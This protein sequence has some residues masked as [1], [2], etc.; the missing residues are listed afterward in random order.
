M[1]GVIL[2]FPPQLPQD[3]D[4]VPSELA[5]PP[6]LEKAGVAAGAE[7]GCEPQLPQLEP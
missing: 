6:G 1:V 5:L 4:A 2:E 3:E 7:A